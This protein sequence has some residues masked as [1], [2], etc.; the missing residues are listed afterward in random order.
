MGTEP[1]SCSSFIA[2]SL[3]TISVFIHSNK[4]VPPLGKCDV[5]K[6]AKESERKIGQMHGRKWSKMHIFF[7]AA[8]IVHCFRQISECFRNSKFFLKFDDFL[9]LELF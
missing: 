1:V 2:L 9:Q 4:F 7:T 6:A 3:A 5:R 8:N